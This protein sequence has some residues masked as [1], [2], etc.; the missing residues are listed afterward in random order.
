MK[1][2]FAEEQGQVVV[3]YILAL[4]IAIMIVAIIA[5]GFRKSLISLWNSWGREISAACPG[6]PGDQGLGIRR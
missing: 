3:E 6:C 1:G 2:F 4:S 5:T